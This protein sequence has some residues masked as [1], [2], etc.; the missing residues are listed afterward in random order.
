MRPIQRLKVFL[1]LGC[2]LVAASAS[3]AFAN[4]NTKDVLSGT[5]TA[6]SPYG[7][8]S[9]H[10]EQCHHKTHS[11]LMVVLHGRGGHTQ[12][13]KLAQR[14]KTIACSRNLAV[15]VPAASS[16]NQNWPF[17]REGGDKQDL[18]LI[19]ILKNEIQK[20]TKITE[21]SDTVFIG[22]SAG[23][24]FL[25]GDF[26][27]RHANLYRGAA[28]AL[29]GG[30]W[31]TDKSKLKEKENFKKFP[32][33]LRISKKDF[34]Y[35]QSEAGIRTYEAHGIPVIKKI[36]HEQGHCNFPLETAAEELLNELKSKKN[37]PRKTSHP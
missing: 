3:H 19:E 28:I 34:L 35:K 6:S 36:T 24:T 5:Y 20:K 23:A 15:V 10:L 17:E 21:P 13:D 18:F 11:G 14:F 12:L 9:F 1:Q 37:R 33:T 2:V 16:S 30:S 4:A 32:L 7:N 26:Y 8:T 29:C 22:I 27:P 31:P 25:M